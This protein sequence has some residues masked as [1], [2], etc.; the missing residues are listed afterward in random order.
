MSNVS[1]SGN[2]AV[3]DPIIRCENLTVAYGKEVVLREVNLEIPRGVFL[4]IIG[5]NGA[6]K[7]TLL[8]AILGLLPP[9][10]GKIITPFYHSHPGYVPQQ[11][12][13][14][15]LY[16]VSIRQIVMMGLYPQLGCFGR[17]KAGQKQKLDSVLARL[18]LL[19]HS[20]K[21]YAELSGGMRQKTLIARALIGDAKVLAMDEPTSELDEVSEKEVIATLVKLAQEEGHTILFTI[22][23]LEPIRNISS[24]VCIVDHG[25]VQVMEADTIARRGGIK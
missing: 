22:H 8:R 17:L 12:V 2:T 16:P 3:G 14:D 5:P 6:G 19:E 25:V 11:K 18:G 7:T 1:T 10:S 9:R 4:P 21:R 23:G 15:P 13:I 20:E 24:H